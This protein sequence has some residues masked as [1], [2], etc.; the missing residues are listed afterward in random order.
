MILYYL[1]AHEKPRPQGLRHSL[2]LDS[3]GEEE[4]QVIQHNTS[5]QRGE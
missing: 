2:L 3:S 5:N 4:A 1:M